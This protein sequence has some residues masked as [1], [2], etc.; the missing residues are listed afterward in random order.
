[1]RATATSLLVR[2][3]SPARL[4]SSVREGAASLGRPAGGLLRVRNAAMLQKSEFL[5]KAH[6]G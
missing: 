5:A 1:M 6:G 3:E 2:G 4:V